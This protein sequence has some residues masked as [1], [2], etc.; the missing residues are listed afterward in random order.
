MQT[1]KSPGTG[2]RTRIHRRP[3]HAQSCSEIDS[4]HQNMR[5]SACRAALGL[6]APLFCTALLAAQCRI[7]RN[8][9]C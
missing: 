3:H 6:Q 2:P 7:D 5:I 9:W 4:S 1:A 8:R